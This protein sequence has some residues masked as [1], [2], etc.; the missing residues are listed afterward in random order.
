MVE[1][2]S[3]ELN[4][5]SLLWIECE[6]MLAYYSGGLLVEWLELLGEWIESKKK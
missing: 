4:D 5:M 6:N 1:R 3:G 2:K